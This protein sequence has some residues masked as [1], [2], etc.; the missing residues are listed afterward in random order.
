MHVR[1][2]AADDRGSSVLPIGKLRRALLVASLPWPRHNAGRIVIV[3]GL[4]SRR[5]P[6]PG[7]VQP[8][9]PTPL[10]HHNAGGY[11]AAGRGAA[12]GRSGGRGCGLN[13]GSSRK[14]RGRGRQRGG[15]AGRRRSGGRSGG[16]SQRGVATSNSRHPNR[17][18]WC[19]R[20]QCPRRA[21][22]TARSADVRRSSGSVAGT[23]ASGAP[24]LKLLVHGARCPRRRDVRPPSPPCGVRGSARSGRG[25]PSGG[26]LGGPPPRG[27][28]ARST[29]S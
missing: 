12:R 22:A 4:F 6:H 17:P 3:L 18:L 1:S 28:G 26:G 29:A 9:A 21:S 15:G 25:A 10:M 8:W 5:V 23:G 14:R 13:R 27:S 11:G 2:T 7:S 16:P 24:V 19:A 20:R